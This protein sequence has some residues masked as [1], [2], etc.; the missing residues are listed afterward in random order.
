MLEAAGDKTCGVLGMNGESEESERKE[1]NTEEEDNEELA[2]GVVGVWPMNDIHE[3][4]SDNIN[5]KIL[6]H[7]EERFATWQSRSSR[8]TRLLRRYCSSQ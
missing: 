1:K 6:C 2:E 8:C 5:L 4:F 3:D 7:C